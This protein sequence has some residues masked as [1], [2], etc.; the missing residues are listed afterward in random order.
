LSAGNGIEIDSNT[1]S[2]KTTESFKVSNV[3]IGG[4][5]DGMVISENTPIVDILKTIL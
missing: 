2:A 5:V 3:N 1:I 4:Y